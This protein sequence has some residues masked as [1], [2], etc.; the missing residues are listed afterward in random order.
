[1]LG[2]MRLEGKGTEGRCFVSEDQ[3]TAVGLN[4]ADTSDLE[5]SNAVDRCQVCRENKLS[6]HLNNKDSMLISCIFGLLAFLAFLL[7]WLPDLIIT[8][9]RERLYALH[10]KLTMEVSEAFDALANKGVSDCVVALVND[11]ICIKIHIRLG[12]AASLLNR[13]K[14]ATLLPFPQ[15]VANSDIKIVVLEGQGG[16]RLCNL[17]NTTVTT[18]TGINKTFVH[19]WHTRLQR[20]VRRRRREHKRNAIGSSSSVSNPKWYSGEPFRI[21]PGMSGS[22]VYKHTN[23][24]VIHSLDANIS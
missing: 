5:K 9:R 17:R 14:L 24:P 1:M 2:G 16:V 10:D 7:F 18:R 22:R 6:E 23:F 3:V 20:V 8:H 15:S 21:E 4:D 11:R 12:S 19:C 13:S